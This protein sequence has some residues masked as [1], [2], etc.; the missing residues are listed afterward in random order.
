MAKVLVVFRIFPKSVNVDLSELE[1]KIVN[2]ISPEKIEREPIA[3]GLV[4]L[5]A[6][7]LVEDQ[8]GEIQKVEEKLNSISSISQV[9]IVEITR[10]L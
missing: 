1:E 3:F 5:K 9:E 4:A 2:S 10:T 7:K 6:S 8:E